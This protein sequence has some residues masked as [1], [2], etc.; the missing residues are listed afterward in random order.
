MPGNSTWVFPRMSSGRPA[1]SGMNR[2]RPRSSSGSTP[3][4][5]ASISHSRCS[6]WST[7]GLLG[8]QV[9]GLGPVAGAVQLPDVV[10][11]GRQLRAQQ[12]PGRAVLGDRGPAAVVDAAVAGDLEVLRL[13]PF[14]RGRVVEGV[15]HAH[16]L[17]GGLGDPVHGG[18]LGQAGGLQDG[19]RD[20]DDVGE[21]LA[22][23]ASGGDPG[24]PVHDGA[25]AGAAPVR[26][27]LL[28]PLVRGAHRV[29]PAH[30]V[31]VVGGR[32]A[33]LGCPGAQ[34]VRASPAR[35]GR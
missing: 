11:E 7:L 23:L 31:V 17:D 35:S 25:V 33:E 34:E 12:L 30:R 8:G 15:A 20:V 19:R 2:S 28:G 6:R 13:V 5:V 32:G 18:G 27:H 21:L 3:C 29:R 9:A 24:G 1:S 26:G 10:V 22:D 4:L 16:A 14:G